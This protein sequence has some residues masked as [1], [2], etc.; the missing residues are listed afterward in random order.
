MELKVIKG[1]GE[2]KVSARE[3]HEFLEI[4]KFNEE[5]GKEVGSRFNDWIKNMFEYGFVEEN[6]Y[7]KIFVECVRGQ[8]KYDF[9]M[10]LDMAKEVS[11]IQRTDK[12]KEAR[13]YFIQIEKDYK[14]VQNIVSEN[15]SISLDELNEIR[16]KTPTKTC[17][18]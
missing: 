18:T 7:T 1:H 10:T 6:D 15:K 2:F 12:G 5:K 17:L 11:M 3:L 14:E 9:L 16:F 4:R 8:N 13:Q